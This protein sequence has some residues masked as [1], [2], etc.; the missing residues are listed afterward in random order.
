[1]FYEI[2]KK[3]CDKKGIT[4]TKASIEIGF[5]RG[6]VSYWKKKYSAGEDVKP[7]S[8]TAA[9]I[10]NYFGV[11]VD[12][13]LGLR[14]FDD[15]EKDFPSAASSSVFWDMF[16][17]LCCTQ[18]KSPNGVAKDLGI[19]SG[20]ITSWKQGRVPH[21]STLLKLAAYF[22]VSVDYLLG[23]EDTKKEAPDGTSDI[24]K[25][26]LDYASKMTPEN[27]KALIKYMEFLVA[28]QNKEDEE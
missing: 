3:L 23:K 25:A 2:F 21:H 28:N 26:I 4:P 10:A 1:M 17:E 5:S 9:K 13:L 11:S 18:K 24:D 19:S 27:R 14:D 16:Y 22:G 12:Y 15:V 7:D 8:Y 6:S 20:A